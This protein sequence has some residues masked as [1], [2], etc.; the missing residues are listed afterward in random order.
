M[1]KSFIV[2]IIVYVIIL[3]LISSASAFA[4]YTYMANNILYRKL[5]GSQISVENA[6]NELYKKNNNNGIMSFI[7]SNTNNFI[8]TEGL[9]TFQKYGLEPTTFSDNNVIKYE[10]NENKIL[11]N[12]FEISFNIM[13][14]NSEAKYMGYVYLRLY[15][16]NSE[17]VLIHIGDAWVDTA[18][19]QID[20][21][22]NGNMY[23]YQRASYNNLSGRY[24]IVGD[25]EKV[26]F[27]MGN[28][29]INSMNFN[30]NISYD[31]IEITYES[32]KGYTVMP[33]YVE[34]IYIG[35]PLFH[36]K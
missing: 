4:T 26:Y 6:L 28:I 17:I 5:D 8:S 12:K 3:G 7:N 10:K 14:D 34:D 22:I 33:M 13:M 24:S 27:Y 1:R 25:G 20:A 15:K 32:Y 11:D 23:A 31:K 19:S 29:L 36:A 2:K 35:K 30:E 21:S 18:T 9:A 16:E